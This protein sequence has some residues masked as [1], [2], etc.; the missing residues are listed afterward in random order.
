MKMIENGFLMDTTKSTVDDIYKKTKIE[1]QNLKDDFAEV[2]DFK[3]TE[4]RRAYISAISQADA[5]F[6]AVCIEINRAMGTK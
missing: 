5:E 3:I 2:K 6:K 1:L 4:A